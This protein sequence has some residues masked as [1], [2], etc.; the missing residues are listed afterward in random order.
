MGTRTL[1]EF[2]FF[3]RPSSNVLYTSQR[4]INLDILLCTRCLFMAY[5]KGGG[6]LRI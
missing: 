5:L 3:C 2:F 4:N 1:N 6:G